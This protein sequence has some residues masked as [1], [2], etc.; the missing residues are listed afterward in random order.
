MSE[1]SERDQGQTP[2]V[3]TT[4]NDITAEGE[5]FLHLEVSDDRPANEQSIQAAITPDITA[6]PS[7]SQAYERAGTVEH[8]AAQRS[9]PPLNTSDPEIK[10]RLAVLRT[11]VT[12]LLT[13]LR[14]EGA[15]IDE[16]ALRLS[17]LLNIG[18]VVQW[19]SI[20]IPFL[21][22][23]DRAGALLPIWLTILDQD[24]M[25]NLT[26]EANP[27]ETPEGRARRYAILMLG[28]YRTMGITGAN[29][30]DSDVATNLPRLLGQLATDPNVSL[31]ATEA[32]VKQ[33]TV[34]AMQSLI[35]A[36]KDARG[37]AKVDVVEGCLALKQERFYDVV[38]SRGLDDAPGLESY[39]A[40]PIYRTIPIE[41]YFSTQH[42]VSPHLQANAALI[43]QR[44]L[45]ESINP[46]RNENAKPPVFERYFPTVA[47]ELFAAARRNPTWQYAVA[48][49]YLG[50]LMGRYWNEISRN[51]MKDGSIIEQIYAVSTQMNDVER[52]M[53]GPG[54]EALLRAI[55]DP[56]EENVILIARI[57][58][59]IREPRATT[60]LIER[61]ERVKTSGDRT[62]ALT[63]GALCEA[64]GRI[65]EPRAALPYATTHQADNRYQPP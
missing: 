13:S 31:Y 19:Q 42:E 47:Q 49:H 29:H 10:Q 62:H 37:W 65:G 40:N 39:I 2:T 51:A 12:R 26:P 22:E 60:P 25:A 59:E 46:P 18:P 1:M 45:R 20:L 32:L 58:G 7:S 33:A 6:A 43:V 21:Y 61:L 30:S 5:G 55:A 17:A 52:W 56:Q 41:Q 24:D 27:A 11:E 14:W 36:L 34:P 28:N 63:L 4:G 23:I 8:L 64:L 50:L 57:L 38:I 15:T 16:T 3:P 48:L 44:V 9:F 53:S 54:R 35:E